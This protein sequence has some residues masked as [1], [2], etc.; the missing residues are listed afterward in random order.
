MAAGKSL[1]V[2]FLRP[3]SCQILLFLVASSCAISFRAA[4]ATAEGWG[5]L[6][7]SGHLSK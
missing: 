3:F 6:S 7:Q 4:F 2:I 5:R 1:S